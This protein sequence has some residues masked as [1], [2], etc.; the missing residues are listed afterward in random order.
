MSR[1]LEF[2]NH[3]HTIPE[4]GMQE[5]KTSAFIADELEKMGYKVSRNIGGKTGIVALLDSGKE[6]KTF[7]IRA[8]MDA[9]GH[10]IDGKHCAMHTCG[11]DAHSSMLLAA[12][13]E[14][15]KNNIVKKGKLK[16]LFQPA[17]EIG[18]GALSMIEGGALEGVDYLIGTHLRPSTEAKLGEATPA[19]C[20]SASTV[21]IVKFIGLQAHGAR[22]HL[23]VNAIDAATSAINAV[24]AIHLDPNLSYSAKAT[25]FICDAGVTNSIPALATV[26]W[27]IRSQQNSTMEIL[28]EKIKNAITAGATTVGATVE[29]TIPMNL[30]ATEYDD[31][32]TELLAEAISSVLGEKGLLKPVFTPGGE[33]FSY[34]RI[35]KPTLKAGF[36]GL[37]C[38]LTPGLHHPDMNFDKS[39]LESGVAIHTY[40]VKK[41]LG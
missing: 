27:D 38:N 33:D 40:A 13:E 31:E 7:A 19:I 29:F 26:T 24:N 28:L 41:I 3:L 8:D 30:P 18:T 37:G 32:M 9:L 15:M 22:P 17:E 10:I 16:L 5:V 14:I 39:A 35:K 6:G 21:L 23:G 1:V 25:R 2:Y 20:Y 12:A 11:H 4:L 36:F 34:Y